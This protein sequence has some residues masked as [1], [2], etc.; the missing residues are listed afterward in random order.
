MGDFSNLKNIVKIDEII[1]NT[2]PLKR[3]INLSDNLIKKAK[4]D[5]LPDNIINVYLDNN[6][7]NS[8][9]WDDRLWGI[10]S[11]KNNNFDT[12]EFD[13]FES[14]KLIL[15]NNDIKEITFVNCKINHL[16]II[17]NNIIN[18]N[19]FDCYIERLDLSVNKLTNIITLPTAL[20]RLS[21]DSNKIHEILTNFEESIDY[22]DLSDNKL[23][24]LP[25]IPL[26]IKHLDLSKNNFVSLDSSIIPKTLEFF[27]ISNNKIKNNSELFNELSATIL[28]IYYDTDSDD[29]ITDDNSDKSDISDV[30]DL[31][32]IKLNYLNQHLSNNNNNNKIKID[33]DS[34]YD[35]DSESASESNPDSDINNL[36][37][38]TNI[39]S[40]NNLYDFENDEKI[41]NAINEYENKLKEIE[42]IKDEKKILCN[43]YGLNNTESI[44]EITNKRELILNAAIN[45]FRNNNNN[46]KDD[47]INI[48]NIYL[49][50]IPIELKWNINLN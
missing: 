14:E 32:E 9:S 33:S 22:L 24:K 34:D 40:N 46:Y 43:I 42:G 36:N 49:S 31:S 39:N 47:N 37:S 26:S 25:N 48:K 16:S 15:D 2:D 8:V 50:L 13:G 1:L 35:P 4:L 11:I 18:I 45:R 20:K 27:D 6:C 21:L 38:N 44:E 3:T 28:Q 30:S 10:I 17:N 19:F 12:N 41:H 7:V 29:E 23:T 5:L